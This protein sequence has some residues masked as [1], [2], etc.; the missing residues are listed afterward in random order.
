MNVHCAFEELHADDAEHEEDEGTESEDD[1]KNN[2]NLCKSRAVV[3][4][5]QAGVTVH[6]VLD[7]RGL[8]PIHHTSLLVLHGKDDQLTAKGF[9]AFT[10]SL[11]LVDNYN[12]NN[13]KKIENLNLRTV[14][15]PS[16]QHVSK[17]SICLFIY[18]LQSYSDKTISLMNAV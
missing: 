7:G 11:G 9:N 4:S 16:A 6:G 15:Y 13:T 14:V 2:N 12:I 8:H 10:Q 18:L 5:I 1:V 17:H 3:P